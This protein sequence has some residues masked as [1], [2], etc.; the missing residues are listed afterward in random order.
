ME[1]SKV[2]IRACITPAILTSLVHTSRQGL[3]IDKQNCLQ[4]S[5]LI[6]GTEPFN[7]K[8]NSFRVS[9]SLAA[10]LDVLF[11]AGGSS[12]SRRMDTGLPTGR[13]VHTK[14]TIQE[15]GLQRRQ[16]RKQQPIVVFCQRGCPLCN[17]LKR[18]LRASKTESD[19]RRVTLKFCRTDS[20]TAHVEGLISF[21][22]LQCSTGSPLPAS[23]CLS[24]LY[25]SLQTS[26]IFPPDTKRSLLRHKPCL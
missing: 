15:H 11:N 9:W 22:L 7:V 19:S 16:R 2:F 17:R 12:S 18:Q 5:E 20:D 25:P 8:S 1:Q 10:C 13:S 6:S 23:C 21:L 24:I 3:K 4:N 14:E 26:T